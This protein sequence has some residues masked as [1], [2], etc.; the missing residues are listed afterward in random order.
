VLDADGLDRDGDVEAVGTRGSSAPHD[1]VIRL[2]RF[3]Q[4]E[5]HRALVSARAIDRREQ[6]TPST[7]PEH[8]P[9]DGAAAAGGRP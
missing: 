2:E 5:P 9:A 7:A 8:H 4:A 6:P 1:G 3:R